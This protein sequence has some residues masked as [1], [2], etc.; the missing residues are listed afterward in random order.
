MKKCGLVLRALSCER[1][2]NP[3]TATIFKYVIAE[4]HPITEPA[5]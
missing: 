3:P 2:D 1:L 4:T 5:T